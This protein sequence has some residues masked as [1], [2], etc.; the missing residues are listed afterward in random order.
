MRLRP[1]LALALLGAGCVAGGERGPS[2][3]VGADSV[4][5]G[6]SAALQALVDE[7]GGGAVAMVLPPRE[8]GRPRRVALARRVAAPADAVMA[9]LRDI[10]GYRHDGVV[11]E[12]DDVVIERDDDAG[13][14]FAAELV[15]PF[16]NLEYT[17]QY[18][19]PSPDRIEVLGVAGALEG[20]RWCW[21]TFPD[22]P[23]ALVVYTSE[24]ELAETN[25]VL[26]QVLGL[27]PDIQP[28]LAFAQGLRFLESFCDAAERAATEP[29]E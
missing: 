12:R 14:R 24:G 27:H 28:G 20:G 25:F 1:R 17:L 3:L 5:V 11:I 19:F 15:L 23:G 2:A 26:R 16:N 7:S 8:P 13:A 6:G 29:A 22:D 18:D 4:G 9:V 10:E 21:Q